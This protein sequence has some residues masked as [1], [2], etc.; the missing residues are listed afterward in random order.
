MRYS[1]TNCR[2]TLLVDPMDMLTVSC[3]RG[4]PKGL[5]D[6][7]AGGPLTGVILR[8]G[9]IIHK[10]PQKIPAGKYHL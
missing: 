4:V 3:A 7:L 1:C 9:G 10:I 6:K 8:T 2:A 5:G